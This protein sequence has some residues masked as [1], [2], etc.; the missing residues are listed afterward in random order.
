MEDDEDIAD[1]ILLIAGGCASGARRGISWSK[2]CVGG[3]RQIIFGANS[4]AAPQ[5]RRFPLTMSLPLSLSF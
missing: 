1:N 5:R 2:P 3:T 4:G